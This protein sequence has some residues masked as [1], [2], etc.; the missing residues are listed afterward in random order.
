MS[1]GAI[2]PFTEPA[3]CRRILNLLSPGGAEVLP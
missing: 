3:G 2:Q 1:L